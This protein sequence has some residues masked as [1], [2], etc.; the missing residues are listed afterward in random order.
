MR[1]FPGFS[2][3]RG[4]SA[5]CEVFPGLPEVP[6]AG[7]RTAVTPQIPGNPEKNLTKSDLSEASLLINLYEPSSSEIVRF[8]TCEVFPRMVFC[9]G[10]R[11]LAIVAHF[12]L[13]AMQM[14]I[15]TV[16]SPV[17]PSPTCVPRTLS[18]VY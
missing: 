5:D 7:A 16:P 15:D 12:F 1:F 6:G 2:G 14:P 10:A 4:W 8:G 3:S 18:L 13:W 17:Q 11:F 9:C